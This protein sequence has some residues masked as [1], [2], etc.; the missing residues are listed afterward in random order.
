MDGETHFTI[1]T[2]LAPGIPE[3][4]SDRYFDYYQ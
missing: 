3:S 4:V 2:P 1:L